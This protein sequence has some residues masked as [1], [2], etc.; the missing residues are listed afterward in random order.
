VPASGAS[1]RRLWLAVALATSAAPSSA[2]AEADAK[3][4]ALVA[5]DNSYRLWLL[6]GD[7][8]VLTVGVCGW[9]PKWAWAGEP[10]SAAKATGEELSFTSPLV[11]NK[12]GGETVNVGCLARKS[13]D[14]ALTWRYE[15]TADKDLPITMLVAGFGVAREASSG[16]ILATLADG[17]EKS[18][19]VPIPRMG[20]TGPAAKLAFKLKDGSEATVSLDPPLPIHIESNDLR[21][22]LATD[23]LKKGT[24]TATMTITVPGTLAF[25][26]KQEDGERFVKTMAGPD[27]FEFAPQNDTG[28][29]VISMNGWLEKPAGKRGGVRMVGDHFEL[30]DATRIKFWGVNL[31]YALCAPE[32]KNA[33]ATAAR[34]AKHGV[35]AVRLHKFCG[36]SGWEGIGDHTD[37][38]KLDPKGLER[39]DYFC[40]QLTQHG[41]Y[42]GFSHTFGFKV[43]P[44]NRDRL[45]AYDEILQHFKGNTY[46]LINVAE[47]VQDLMIEM[48]VG[49]LKHKNPHTGTTYAEDPA[50]CYVEM[51]NEDD[52]FF[53]TN[54]RA[55]NACPTYRK[56][57]TERFADWLKQK[58]GTQEKLAQAWADALKKPETLEARNIAL[59]GNP[60]FMGEDHLPKTKGG[61]RLRLLDN[62]AFYHDVQNTFYGRFAKAIRDAGYKGPLVGSPWQA[63]TML[64]HYYNL[65]SD[66][67]VGYVDRHNY[68]GG[69][70]PDT[71]LAHPG[72]GYFGSG[73]QQ[74]LDRPFGLSE[75]IHVYPSLYSAEGPAILAA[76]G[77]GLQGWDAS[78]EFQSFS[79]RTGFASSVGGFPWGVWEADL[80]TQLGQY[81]ALSRMILRGDVKEGEIISTRRLSL[82]E[83]QE[84]K[85]SFSDRVTQSGDIKAFTGSVP[86]E[87]L[88]AG[89]VVVEFTDKPQP[90]TFPD[91]AKYRK[92]SVITSA[93]GQ[94]AW[95]VSGKGFFTVNADGTKAVVGFAEG[96]EIAL[97][98]AKIQ[99][100]SPYASIFLTA[101]D[102]DATLANAK[103]ALLSAVARNS[104]SGFQYLTLDH[105]VLE[106]GKPPV[107]LEPVKA[108]ITITGRD[109]AAVNVLDHDGRRTGR[110]IESANGSFTI[111]GARDKAIYYEVVFK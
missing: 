4:V 21:V 35:N 17:K 88:A 106:N 53:Y 82:Q 22:M 93:T 77:M 46:A 47:D 102:K 57:L 50:L 48:V 31:S 19:P 60:W 100:Q 25:L 6:K 16:E 71:M 10:K 52:I 43:Q 27:W 1:S 67:L 66:Y 81:P 104:N 32:K 33:E 13:G 85:F 40:S 20:A 68:F 39:L 7:Q 61:E 29:S 58:Y 76:Y 92:D 69:K 105:R 99:M 63:P 73:L 41:I 3:W 87:A 107:M 14:R 110:T 54:D 38:T 79:N 91:M 103:S 34:Y 26:A 56:R 98:N 75:W 11:I 42:Y 62:A 74:V 5:P 84:G 78:Y 30:E 65:R 55:L 108:K 23:L 64:P 2:A 9:G 18:I 111:D 83:L 24:T 96:K 95:D 90:S 101:L 36:P 44:G 51:H 72:S 94:L 37:A 109:I 80:P 8:P 15:L 97:G 28:P 86:P 59:Q 70:I 89:R 49:L 12:D 45:L